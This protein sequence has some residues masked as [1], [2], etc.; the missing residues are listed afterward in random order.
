MAEYGGPGTSRRYVYH[1]GLAFG[2]RDV[3]LVLVVRR[4][5]SKQAIAFSSMDWFGARTLSRT[6]TLNLLRAF[7]T[8]VRNGAGMQLAFVNTRLLGASY[9]HGVGPQFMDWGS[10][11]KTGPF[12][13]AQGRLQR[14]LQNRDGRG[15]RQSKSFLGDCIVRSRG[16][17]PS[18]WVLL[19]PIF[20]HKST[21][22]SPSWVFLAVEYQI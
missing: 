3:D 18:S 15:H 14:R 1:N 17:F 19:C 2:H 6:S 4:I 16:R 21:R 11:A 12:T 8:K 10:T 7:L 13:V 5:I 20:C 22:L 9:R